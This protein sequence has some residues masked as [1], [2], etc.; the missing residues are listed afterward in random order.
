MLA[1]S[2]QPTG[3]DYR[4]TPSCAET[5]A[6]R[7]SAPPKSPARVTFAPRCS[8]TGRAGEDRRL[9]VRRDDSLLEIIQ[10]FTPKNKTPR[11]GEELGADEAEA[12]NLQGKDTK[13]ASILFA[14]ADRVIE[15][16]SSFMTRKGKHQA[17][18]QVLRL[19]LAALAAGRPG[20]A[21]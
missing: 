10:M 14:E 4:M 11:T 9:R 2:L 21:V 3:C 6:G 8:G 15:S 5:A 20:R 16:F 17:E 18:S 12:T 7:A 13:S 1:Y 19:F